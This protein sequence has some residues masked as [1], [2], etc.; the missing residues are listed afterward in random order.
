MQEEE[1]KLA[2]S[3][4]EEKEDEEKKKEEGRKERS[5]RDRAEAAPATER[6]KG[7]FGVTTAAA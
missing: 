7:G 5:F 3:P 4:Q 1:K 2:R 6:G